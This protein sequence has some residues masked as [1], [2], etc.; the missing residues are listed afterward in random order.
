MQLLLGQFPDG[1][2]D[3]EAVLAG[4]RLE[5]AHVPGGDGAGAG[6]GLNGALGQSEVLVGDHEVRVQLHLDAEARALAA[7]AVRAVEAEVAW[8][9]LAEG[10]AAVDAGEVLRVQSLLGGCLPPAFALD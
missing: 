5:D 10:E 8:L 6:P 9:D 4:D 7:G 3:G 2:V 1:H